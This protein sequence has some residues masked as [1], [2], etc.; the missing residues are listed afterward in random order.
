MD[1]FT[2]QRC[3]IYL[4][5]STSMQIDGFSLEAQQNALEAYAKATNME[6]AHCY[7]DAGKSGKSM[8]GRDEFNQML[9]DIAN[10]KDDVSC[11]LVYKLSRFGRNVRDVQNSLYLLQKHNVD[12]YCVADGVNTCN[13]IGKLLISIMGAIAE[14]EAENISQQTMAGRKQKA[15]NGLWNGGQAPYGYYLDKGMLTINEAEAAVVKKI[16]DLYTEEAYGAVGIVKYLNTH[17]YTKQVRGTGKLEH[18]TRKLINDILTNPVYC[19]EITYG[20]RHVLPIDSDR[21]DEKRKVVHQDNYITAEGQ[22]EAIVTKSQFEAAQ[23]RKE[24]LARTCEKREDSTHVH[25]LATIVRCPVCGAKMYGNTTRKKKKDG[26]GD[27]YAHYHFYGCKHRREVE[28]V[29][30]SFK[31]NISE[32]KIDQ[33]VVDVLCKLA[34]NQTLANK[35]AARVGSVTDEEEAITA[36]SEIQKQIDKKRSTARTAAER[37]LLFDDSTPFANE[38]LSDMQNKLNALYGEIEQLTADLA[39]EKEKLAAIRENKLTTQRIYEILE[40]FKNLYDIMTPEDRQLLMRT[41]I[42]EVH[43]DKDAQP[44]EKLVKKIVLNIP[45]GYDGG[46]PC[47][48]IDPNDRCLDKKTIDESVVTLVKNVG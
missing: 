2:K 29:P 25:L 18:F 26:S 32:D 45:I 40:R 13:S 16:F 30:C 48:T 3:Y 39:H 7:C 38:I 44:G 28:G 33:P 34:S 15:K 22:H 42:K 37:I 4:R 46:A 1:F 43:I 36:I 21:P 6:V 41:L 8:V 47:I 31:G 11:V 10:H 12:L 35:I 14:M 17:G 27:Y 24:S 5:V 19:G 20:R 23:K 9:E